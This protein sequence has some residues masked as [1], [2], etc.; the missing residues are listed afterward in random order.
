MNKSAYRPM[1]VLLAV[2][3]TT[4]LMFGACD[5][6]AQQKAGK[7]PL[8][9]TWTAVSQETTGPDG[10]KSQSFGA[11]PK[12]ILTFDANGRYALQICS[13]SRPKFASNVRT[14]GTADENR[15]AVHGCN[16][17]WGRYSVSDGAIN[18]Q[19]EHALFPNWEGTEQKRPFTIK[20]DVLKYAV[21]TASTGGTAEL[22]WKRAK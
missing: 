4:A 3:G 7:N 11:D 21:P 10:K 22:V 9:G 16:P 8:V 19:I 2:I 17:H 18:F 5:V 1:Q 20:G 15:A 14:T 6:W 13:S 12:G